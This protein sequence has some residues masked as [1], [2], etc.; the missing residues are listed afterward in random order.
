MISHPKLS[1]DETLK[2]FIICI[3][4][5][6][7]ES[8]MTIKCSSVAQKSKER[9]QAWVFHVLRELGQGESSLVWFEL[10]TDTKAQSTHTFLSACQ[11]SVLSA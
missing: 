3:I 5:N 1:S 6:C 4:I 9:R 10:I 8:R 11:R 2:R 7:E